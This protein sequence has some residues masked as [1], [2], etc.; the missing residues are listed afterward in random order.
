M[1]RLLDD[2]IF[3]DT[4]RYEAHTLIYHPADADELQ[5]SGIMGA[6]ILCAL[7]A[8]TDEGDERGIALDTPEQ[9]NAFFD[10]YEREVR[11]DNGGLFTTEVEALSQSYMELTDSDALPRICRN[12]RLYDLAVGLVMDYMH[13]LVHEQVRDHIYEALPWEMPFAQWLYDAGFVETARQHLLAVNWLDA[14]EVYA[15]AQTWGKE[16]EETFPPTFYF[17]SEN[18]EQLMETYFR[19]LWEQVQAQ[20]SMMPD[21]KVELA[22][23]TP[24]VLEKETDYAFLQPELKQLAPEELNLFRKWLKQWTEFVTRKLSDNP[25]STFPKPVKTPRFKQ[26]LFADT[27]LPCPPE[28]NY[29]AVC[30]YIDERRRYDE[31]FDTFYKVRTRVRLCEQLTAMFGW[32]VDPGFLGSRI[33]Y[34]KNHRK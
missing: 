18:A 28:N 8:D 21:A 20:T 13:R 2:H 24:Y 19:W 33:N 29:V 17:Q 15:L 10:R 6:A 23:T 32:Y 27:I 14:A 30:D 7:L 1:K 11:R 5:L 3:D 12:D 34:R 25:Q 9:R 26:E 22:Q 16:A 4:L 31:A